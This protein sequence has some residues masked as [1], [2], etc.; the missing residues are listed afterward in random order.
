MRRAFW[1]V[2]SVL[3][4]SSSAYAENG[5]Y[6]GASLGPSRA[7]SWCEDNTGDCEDVALG[8]KAYMGTQFHPNWAIE[9]AFV[10]L[11]EFTATD[12]SGGF[13]I[14]AEA[15]VTGF[16]IA[17]I[18]ILPMSPT[19]AFLGR[20]GVILSSLD[21]QASGG[22]QSASDR[23]SNTSLAVGLGARVGITDRVFARV[24]W[25][26]F[27]DIGDDE[28]GQDDVDFLSVGLGMAF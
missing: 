14:D 20:F 9:A 4:A 24:E 22:G 13:P 6:V 19:F 16:N 1:V 26:R 11:G 3:A 27:A 15:E 2:V 5:I 23:A 21:I 12:T 10:D 17:A 7:V 18:G 25:E 28:T 8:W